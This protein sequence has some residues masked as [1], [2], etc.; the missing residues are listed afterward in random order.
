MTRLSSLKSMETRS[1]CCYCGVGCGVI[2]EHDGATVLG[3]RGDPDHPANWGKL[4]TKGSTLHLSARP[5][6]RALTPSLRFNRQA[7][8]QPSSW[9]DSLDFVA[10]KFAATIQEYGPDSVA[11]YIS[12]QLLTEDYFVF[13]KLAKGLIGTNNVDTNSRLCMSSAVAGYKITLGADAPPACYEDIDHAGLMF[14]TGANMAY[15][16]P[17]LFRRVEAAKAAHPERKIIVVDP[18]RTDT[19]ELAD[20]HLAIIPGTDVALY[21]GMLHWLIWEDKIDRD[22]IA[23]HTENFAALKKLVLS[24]TPERAAG[25]C[26]ITKEDLILAAQ[27]WSESSSVLSFYCMGLNQSSDGTNKNAALINIHLATAQI[28]KVGAGPFSLTGQPNAMG[29]RE[30]GGMANLLSAHRNLADPVHRAEVAALWQIPDV[31]AHP[32]KTAVE[33]FEAVREGKIKCIWIACTNPAHSMP[34]LTLVQEALQK[35]ELVVVQDAY[36]DTETTA[37]ADVLLPA[38]SWAEKDGTVTNSERRISRVQAAVPAPAQ[39]RHDWD[40]VVDFAQRLEARLP[41][42]H[43]AGGSLFAYAD[44]D[45]SPAN[46]KIFNEHR[47]STLGRDLDI[48]GISYTSLANMPTQWPCKVDEETGL[49]RL[50]GDGIFPTAS[51]KAQFYAQDYHAPTEAPS[52]RYPIRLLTGRLRDQWHTMTRTGSVGKL[53]NHAPE[54]LITLHPADL[55][56]RSIIAGSLI[57]VSNKRGS[58]IMRCESSDAMQPS[59]AFIPMHWGARHLA[60]LGANVLTNPAFDPISKQPELKHTLIRLEPVDLPWQAVGY[61]RATPKRMQ[62]LSVLLNQFAYASCH[63]IAEEMDAIV[64]RCANPVAPNAALIAQLDAALGLNDNPFVLRY[65]DVQNSVHKSLLIQDNKLVA[66]RLGGEIAAQGW[67]S[68]A[69]LTGQDISQLRRWL[70]APVAQP[71]GTQNTSKII[72]NCLGVREDAIQTCVQAGADLASLQTQL[73]CGTKCG[74]CV[75]ELKRMVRLYN[76]AA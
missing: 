74:S 72:C 21:H 45:S 5:E 36:Q 17:I 67:L 9:A 70:L 46:E 63:F 35:A 4:C 52:A 43:L 15:A 75:P 37:F 1:T 27:W 28:G 8:R 23:A 7:L 71:P 18:R 61:A 16:H 30:V 55:A 65:E 26:G 59:C 51:G 13:N 12:G 56:R 38:S 19:A 49:A 54:P 20:L 47:A 24:Y 10:D 34:D 25:I 62:A 48:G 3:V 44:D 66:F 33:M 2:I 60:G 76:K 14:I 39:A 68:Q 40:I 41:N 57:K 73:A 22:Y 31:P 53:A 42:K 29:G 50:Y 58:L 6:G 11:F 32:G 64:W 69:L